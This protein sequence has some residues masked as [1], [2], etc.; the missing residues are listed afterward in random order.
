[1]IVEKAIAVIVGVF[2]IFM[3]LAQTPS[4]NSAYTNITSGQSSF[5]QNI[6]IGSYGIASFFLIICVAIFFKIVTDVMS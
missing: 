5:V 3:I 1:M 2:F 6:F 4:L